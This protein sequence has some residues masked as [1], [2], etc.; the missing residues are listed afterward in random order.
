MTTPEQHLASRLPAEIEIEQAIV[1]DWYDGPLEG[2]LTIV[3]LNFTWYFQIVAE[4][5]RSEAPDDRL[6]LLFEAPINSVDRLT[7]V[8]AEDERATKPLWIPSWRFRDPL[9]RKRAD[10]LVA[11]L[12]NHVTEARIILRSSNLLQTEDIWPVTRNFTVN[13]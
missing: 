13:R 8:L 4:K 7:E 1:L 11:D 10:A 5:T 9:T 2:F 6:Y 12:K 3:D